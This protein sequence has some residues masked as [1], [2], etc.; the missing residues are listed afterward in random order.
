MAPR[1]QGTRSGRA[2]RLVVDRAYN[3]LK[4]FR[5]Q[6]QVRRAGRWTVYDYQKNEL[7]PQGTLGDHPVILV[8]GS[9]YV[10]YMPM[11]LQTISRHWKNGDT[12]PATGEPYTEEEARK[13]LAAREPY[14]LKPMGRPDAGGHQRF[15]YPDPHGYIAIDPATGRPMHPRDTAHLTGKI[16]VRPSERITR[17]IQKYPWYSDDWHRAYG[18]RNQV[19]N[20]NKTLKDVGSGELEN[21]KRRTG[22]GI[23]F[24]GLVAGFAIAAENIRRIIVGITKAARDKAP[25]T[26]RGRKRFDVRGNR[27]VPKPRT[28]PRAIAPAEPPVIE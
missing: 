20:S 6:E 9:L 12:N 13:L 18:Q 19:E 10:V 16:T 26:T 17:S 7:G 15:Q 28:E 22:R 5:Y 23:A 3:H 24:H 25:K 11:H 8:D 14:R 2:G 21:K 27:L 1:P 4:A